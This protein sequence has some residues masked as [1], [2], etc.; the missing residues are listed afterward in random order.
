MAFE[1]AAT[2]PVCETV[3][4]PDRRLEDHLC[5]THTQLELAEFIVFQRDR[6]RIE[7]RR[8]VLPGV[9]AEG[10]AGE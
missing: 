7:N 4:A 8:P 6:D 9:S 2:C 3:L 10:T 1:P 5:R